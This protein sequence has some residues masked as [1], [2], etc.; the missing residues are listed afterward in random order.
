MAL[1][2]LLDPRDFVLS[3]HHERGH[4][5]AWSDEAEGLLA[6]II[7]RQR[8]ACGVDGGQHIYQRSFLPMGVQGESVAFAAGIAFKRHG[9]TELA[10]PYVA[11]STRRYCRCRTGRSW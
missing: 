2:R 3:D 1:R 11:D 5:H 7:G 10:M 8:A 9:W 4:Y 6:E